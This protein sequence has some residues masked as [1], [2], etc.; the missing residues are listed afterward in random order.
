MLVAIAAA[1]LQVVLITSDLRATQ[2]AVSAAPPVSPAR[3]GRA[4]L[5]VVRKPARV[6]RSEAERRE[7]LKRLALVL[8][9]PGG[10]FFAPYRGIAK[11]AVAR[12]HHVVSE[13]ALAA[14]TNGP[15]LTKVLATGAAI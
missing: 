2:R 6:V 15:E 12:V 4:A 13:I 3:P 5:Q 9:I 11:R 10:E 1:G 14:R 8:V 7:R